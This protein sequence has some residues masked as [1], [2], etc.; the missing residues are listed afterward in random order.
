M[1]LLV[2]PCYFPHLSWLVNCGWLQGCAFPSFGGSEFC[3]FCGFLFRIFIWG[4]D[5]RVSGL[6]WI[7]VCEFSCGFLRPAWC[8][9]HPQGSANPVRW[10]FFSKKCAALIG[11][12]MSNCS[13]CWCAAHLIVFLPR[14]P[15][16]I[17]LKNAFPPLVA[18]G[19]MVISIGN[20]IILLYS[21]PWWWMMISWMS[22]DSCLNT[23]TLKFRAK[24]TG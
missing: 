13:G 11:F 6:E 12:L 14:L 19:F 7:A 9:I 24:L 5:D 21:S 16:F 4:M 8:P 17:Y 18:V 1:I 20:S 2:F 23:V 22:Q 3:L 15:F 10:A